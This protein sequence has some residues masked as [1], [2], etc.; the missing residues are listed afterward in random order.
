ML[1]VT[2]KDK[3]KREWLVFAT[4]KLGCASHVFT[5]I[6]ELGSWTAQCSAHPFA[7]SIPRNIALTTCGFSCKNFS[8]LFSGSGLRFTV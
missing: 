3:K 2:S 6:S 5:N 7:C 8:K 1:K 4:K